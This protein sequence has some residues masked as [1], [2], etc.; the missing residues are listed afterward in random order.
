MGVLFFFALIGYNLD[1]Y[2]KSKNRSILRE[3][4]IALY[5]IEKLK[6]LYKKL[7]KY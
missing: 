2:I 1:F 3:I 7:I 6:L 4:L 5:Y